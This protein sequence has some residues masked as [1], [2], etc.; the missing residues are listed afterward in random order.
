MIKHYVIL[1]PDGEVYGGFSKETPEVGPMRPFDAPFEGCTQ[2]EVDTPFTRNAPSPT[3]KPTIANGVI[4]WVETSTLEQ[5][6]QRK[7][8]EINSARL[9]ANRSFFIFQN[10]QIA[11]DELSRSDI[12]AVNGVVNLLGVVPINQWKT[13]DNTYTAIPDKQT[14]INF[15]MAMVSTGQAN[16]NKAQSLK[17]SLAD[18]TTIEQIEA[19]KWS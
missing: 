2:V 15:Y 18:A 8:S 4:V 12:D 6:K 19:I 17:S 14:W 5:I 13:L 9:T 16:F 7:N 10:K 3:A 1:D 11:C